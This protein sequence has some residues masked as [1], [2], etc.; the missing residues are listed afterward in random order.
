MTVIALL[1]EFDLYVCGKY[2]GRSGS[3][4]T[5]GEVQ[6]SQPPLPS[7]PLSEKLAIRMRWKPVLAL[8]QE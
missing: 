4:Q 5:V 6:A 3:K 1:S 2:V 7:T 8:A